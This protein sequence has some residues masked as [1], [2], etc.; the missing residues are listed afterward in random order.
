MRI[1]QIR[2]SLAGDRF[3]VSGMSLHQTEPVASL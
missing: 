3:D 1:T 2:A